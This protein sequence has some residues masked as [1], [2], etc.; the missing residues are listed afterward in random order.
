MYIRNVHRKYNIFNIINFKH[1]ILQYLCTLYVFFN[2]VQYKLHFYTSFTHYNSRHHFYTTVSVHILRVHLHTTFS[3]ILYVRLT[4]YI[5]NYVEILPDKSSF[6][7]LRNPDGLR[8]DVCRL[9]GSGRSCWV[10]SRCV[11]RPGCL[12]TGRKLVLCCRKRSRL[13]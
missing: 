4:M 10:G 3:S 2:H 6:H 13:P 9:T 8:D 11:P 7:H 12:C 5:Q 1:F